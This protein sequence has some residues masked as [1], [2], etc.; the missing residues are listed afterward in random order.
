MERIS[1][2]LQRAPWLLI[3]VLALTWALL[4]VSAVLRES[5]APKVLAGIRADVH[6]L[7]VSN[8]EMDSTVG[9]RY[10]SREQIEHLQRRFPQH[11]LIA[12]NSASPQDVRVPSGNLRA[13]IQFINPDALGLT[14]VRIDG[15][16]W[17]GV[18][19]FCAPSR[20]W[21]ERWAVAADSVQIGSQ[22]IP[23]LGSVDPRLRMLGGFDRV[24]LWCTWDLVGG[25]TMPDLPEA[26]IR[27]QPMYWLYV[28]A[29][30]LNDANQW[31]SLTGSIELPRVLGMGPEIHRLSS[32]EGW[33]TH[34]GLQEAALLRVQRLEVLAG[35]LL[36][37]GFALTLF[38]GAQR[39]RKRQ[40]EISIRIALGA[41]ATRL[42]VPLIQRY[43]WVLLVA[44][45]VGA[46]LALVIL[47]WLW[48]DPSYAEVRVSGATV[49]D[50]DWL[51]SAVLLM[52]AGLAALVWE[53]VMVLRALARQRLSETGRAALK[54]LGA[55][56]IPTALVATVALLAC[57]VMLS[58]LRP[59]LAPTP[60]SFGLPAGL[61]VFSARFPANEW[62]FDH[63][64]TREQLGILRDSIAAG[65]PV[66]AFEIIENY[67][68]FS[69]ASM[70][71][72]LIQA[73]GTRCGEAPEMLRGSPGLLGNLVPG[74]LLGSP[75]ATPTD[76]AI[77]RSRALKCFGSVQA[78]LG[79]SLRLQG[80]ALHVSGVYPDFDWNL[81]RGHTTAFVGLLSD[82]PYSYYGVAFG[83]ASPEAIEPLFLQHLKSAL[84]NA[85]SIESATFDAIA[86]QAY[87]TEIAQSRVLMGFG[88][89]LALGSMVACAALF[90][91]VFR[92]R[93]ATFALHI[94]M[95]ASP[96]R[97]LIA[98]SLP[99]MLGTGLLL[100]PLAALVVL[101]VGKSELLSVLLDTHLAVVAASVTGVVL[102][103]AA[104]STWS[105][106]RLLV[107]R[108]I[109]A[110]LHGG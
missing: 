60:A 27:G 15:G 83:V 88:V 80:V 92:E 9:L 64:L 109:V 90:S 10:F 22:K 16:A 97:L 78:A 107:D 38:I 13:S 23:L 70:P 75:P 81:G 37:L 108:R 44:T 19:S 67:P 6:W 43:A 53:M 24:D 49:L 84:P 86:A 56:R 101:V 4:L 39:A 77:A 85:L 105:L 51:P 2:L 102:M 31:R 36:L 55:T 62:A 8:G 110:E 79:A 93:G 32:I 91:A 103:V 7:S 47:Q 68:G 72:N 5:I 61:H 71:G 33:V 25:V 28:G 89:L 58:Q 48:S 87:R 12:A 74:M 41:T 69:G 94:A 98:S 35:V 30:T 14:G 52:L 21:R 57:W 50:V 82:S 76:I 59:A 65:T 46:A 63:V 1:R 104:I 45:A 40:P 18:Q 29:A 100:V 54:G 20:S 106:G 11:R 3:T 99:L 73:D 95:G 17:P 66:G 26:A 96:R 42:L 34:P